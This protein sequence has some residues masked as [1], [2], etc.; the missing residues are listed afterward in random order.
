MIKL[1]VSLAMMLVG[2]A[3]DVYS[4]YLW[5]DGYRAV[6]ISLTIPTFLFM[7]SSMQIMSDYF[8]DGGY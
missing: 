8:D 1:I 7:F 6:A 5:L 2:I 3:I 4:V